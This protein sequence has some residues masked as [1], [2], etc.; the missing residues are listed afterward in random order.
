ME[1]FRPPV[2]TLGLTRTSFFTQ[3]YSFNNFN[4]CM[5][6][7]LE[8]ASYDIMFNSMHIET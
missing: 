1:D 7:M 2:L 8:I 6:K 4:K 5:E 3:N